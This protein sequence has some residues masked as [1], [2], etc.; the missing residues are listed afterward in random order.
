MVYQPGLGNDSDDGIVRSE[1]LRV[2][3]SGARGLPC[4]LLYGC[5]LMPGRGGL[6][7]RIGSVDLSLR[8]GRRMRAKHDTLLL[9]ELPLV[10][11]LQAVCCRQLYHLEAA[12]CSCRD[13]CCSLCQSPGLSV[14]TAEDIT[15]RCKSSC[16]CSQPDIAINTASF[17]EEKSCLLQASCMPWTCR[18]GILASS[19]S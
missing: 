13:F 6:R 2:R 7:K 14:V 5:S 9:V 11:Q 1:G 4:V 16:D 18:L 12:R 17:Y 15:L 10:H 8:F 19:P 3:I